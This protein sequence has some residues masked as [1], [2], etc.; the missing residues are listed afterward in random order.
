MNCV[1]LSF[2]KY[3]VGEKR[4]K[5][6]FGKFVDFVYFLAAIG[7]VAITAGTSGS[8][9]LRQ[10][11]PDL[12]GIPNSFGLTVVFCWALAIIYTLTSM[13]GAAKGK[14]RFDANSHLRCACCSFYFLSLDLPAHLGQYCQC[15]DSN[16]ALCSY[17]IVDRLLYGLVI[18]SL[19][20]YSIWFTVFV[21]GPL[22]GYL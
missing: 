6:H 18:L 5:R 11:F 1:F 22:Q 13:F 15:A 7:S 12:I 8:T 14:K 20:Q 4:V 19:T 10:P 21:F 16:F 9:I 2:G 3:T 17:D